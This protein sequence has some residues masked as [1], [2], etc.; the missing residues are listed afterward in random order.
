MLEHVLTMQE[1]REVELEILHLLGLPSRPRRM[2]EKQLTKSAPKFLLDVYRSLLE[3]ENGREE[4]SA[5]LDISGEERNAID[6]SD[7]IMTFDSISK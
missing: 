7:I 1:K 6:E 3:K 2:S 4:R 5:D